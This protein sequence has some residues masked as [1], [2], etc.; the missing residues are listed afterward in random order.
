M[1]T[2]ASLLFR[3]TA[4]ERRAQGGDSA[5]I[6]AA[7]LG[8]ERVGQWERLARDAAEPNVFAE[9]WTVM[10]A[11]HPLERTGD[12]A[13]AWIAD[14]EGRLIGV[15]PLARAR[16]YGRLPVRHTV[17]W[18][19]A[20]AFCGVPLVRAGAERLFW[21]RLLHLLDRAEEWPGFL[22]L[23]GL[24][25]DGP[26]FAGLCEAAADRGIAVVHRMERAMLRSPLAPDAYWRANVRK[27]KRKELNR[28]AN[29]LAE[30]GH[31]EVE[32]LPA[33]APVEPWIDAFLTL[34]HAG[35]KGRAGS[36]MTCAP[37]T[38]AIFRATVSGAHARRRLH[39]LSLTL[40]GRPVA[41]LATLLAS[42]GAYS[43]K[44]A[45]DEA[46]ARYSPGVLLERQALALLDEPGIEWVDSCAAPGHPMIDSLWGE[47][48]AIVRV[49]VPLAG[50]RRRATHDVA[51]LAETGWSRTKHWMEAIR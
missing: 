27:K 3:Q 35:W 49:T 24:P 48:R 21:A 1:S 42:P 33:Q 43:Y 13:L 11:L 22:H 5:L 8:P 19:H 4:R 20:N 44:I 36:A 46:L 38:E 2:P 15:L 17:N 16:R 18:T 50:L 25:E 45:Y 39:A 47:R 14:P 28:L 12:V 30:Q 9:P 32:R 7:T 34:E 40:D 51:R 37:A 41:M 10:P 6:P 31:V 23:T 26:V 29:R